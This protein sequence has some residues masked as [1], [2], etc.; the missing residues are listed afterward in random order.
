L[1][2]ERQR[3]RD[4][5]SVKK[6]DHMEP[7]RGGFKVRFKVREHLCR[8]AKIALSLVFIRR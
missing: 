7:Y 3:T 8:R 1:T 5:K 6:T 4:G 2:R